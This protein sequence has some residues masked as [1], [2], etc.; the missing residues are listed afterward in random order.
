MVDAWGNV[1]FNTWKRD[2]VGWAS[3]SGNVSGI[4]I[5]NN[6]EPVT[7]RVEERVHKAIAKHAGIVWVGKKRCW[8]LIHDDLTLKM[9]VL[10]AKQS[11]HALRSHFRHKPLLVLLPAN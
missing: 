3:K 6:N 8:W 9:A 7:K 5:G 2:L 10:P 1:G 11:M 4:V